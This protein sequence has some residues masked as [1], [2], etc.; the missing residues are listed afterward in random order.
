MGSRMLDSILRPWDHALS[1][2]QMLTKGSD[3][4]PQWVR[5]R[6]QH[7][8]KAPQGILICSE[9]GEPQLYWPLPPSPHS[10]SGFFSPHLSN[11]ATSVSFLL[12]IHTRHTATFCVCTCWSLCLDALPCHPSSPDSFNLHLNT[13]FLVIS[14]DGF[15]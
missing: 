12:L 11:L 7:F 4:E 10:T 15:M 9:A 8:C 3:P 2:R 14:S 1:Q 13:I 5:P 6:H